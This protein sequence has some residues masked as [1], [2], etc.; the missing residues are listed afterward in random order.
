[1]V[2]TCGKALSVAGRLVF[3]FILAFAFLWCAFAFW[4]QLPGGKF[5]FFAVTGLWAILG[6]IVL[7]GEWHKA[8][9][10][11]TRTLA[12][13]LFAAFAAWWSTIRPSLDLPWALPLSRM[14]TGTIDGHLAYVDNIRDFD[15]I[16]PKEGKPRWFSATYDLDTITGVDAYA[17]YWMGP[18]VSH[19][20]VGFQFAD[21][22]Y[23]VFSAETRPKEGEGFSAVSGF[24]KGY[25][26]ALIAAS[27]EDIIFLRTNIRKEDVYRYPIKMKPEDA[28]ELFKLYIAEGNNLV[29][30]PRFYDTLTT[31]CTTVAFQLVRV[32][33]PGI[34]LDWRI[35]ISG[36]LPGYLYDNGFIDTQWPL[37]EEV[38]KA[39]INVQAEGPREGYS[40]RILQNESLIPLESG[41]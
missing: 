35:L 8:W 17:S 9:R 24:F 26:L 38:R 21:G 15:W 39:Y 32:L 40:K 27:V 28:K 12:V 1:M 20:L 3:C 25:N 33:K 22:K 23:L 18:W 31:N 29:K 5:V 19:T 16:T 14:V 34:P 36:K 11:K 2:R 37:S 30:K 6:F 13:L 4:F 10:W 41:K 7:Y